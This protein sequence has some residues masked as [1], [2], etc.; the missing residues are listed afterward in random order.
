[1]ANN[2]WCY[3]GNKKLSWVCACVSW[4]NRLGLQEKKK[5]DTF[6]KCYNERCPTQG[7]FFIRRLK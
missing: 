1:M 3:L 4:N 6:F 2:S 7:H 5:V